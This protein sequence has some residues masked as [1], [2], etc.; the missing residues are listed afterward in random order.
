MRGVEA[1]MNECGAVL[2]FFGGF[3]E[4][5]PAL[6]ECLCYLD[7]WLPADAYVLAVE[8]A[9][10]LLTD[11]A[12]IELITFLKVLHRAGEFWSEPVVD[13]D[14]FNR[15][16]VPFHVLLNLSKTTSSIEDRF[17]RAA[18]DAGIVVKR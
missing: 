10:E 7:E 13:N 8:R 11:D 6:E 14:R 9:E 16:P 4:N 1:L 3:G 2:Q 5:W 18:R 12:P 15:K 17:A